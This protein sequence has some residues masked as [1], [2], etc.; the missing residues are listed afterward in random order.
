VQFVIL[1]MLL[2][3]PLSLYDLRGR[4]ERVVSLFYSASLGSIQRALRVL[5]EAGHVVIEEVVDS[6][7]G[8]KLYRVTDKGRAAW[9]QWMLAPPVGAE[10][11][12]TMLAK[13]FFL[14]RLNSAADRERV[15]SGIQDRLSAD[16]ERLKSVAAPT[17]ARQDDPLLRYQ[18]ATRD[19]GLRSLD[20]A[21]AWVAELGA[22]ER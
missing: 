18:L 5:A 6:R 3:G 10:T 13:V 22:A 11:E 4:F 15:L 20:L 17:D 14:G 21:R 2:G 19:Y 1:G 7:R 12:R 8:K 9:E 16:A